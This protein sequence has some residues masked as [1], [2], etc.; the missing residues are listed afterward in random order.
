LIVIGPFDPYS[1]ID[2]QEHMNRLAGLGA[3]SYRD[4]YR[5]VGRYSAAVAEMQSRYLEEV[6]R[7]MAA[8]A[9]NENSDN[10]LLLLIEDETP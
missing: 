3:D 10:E 2:R 9:S 1:G 4:P 5:S 8:G 7:R 6:S